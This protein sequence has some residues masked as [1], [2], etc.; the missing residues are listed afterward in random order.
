MAPSARKAKDATSNGKKGGKRA[1]HEEEDEDE[2]A[3]LEAGS[4]GQWADSFIVLCAV[5]WV[6]KSL[7]ALARGSADKANGRAAGV[8]GAPEGSG[9]KKK[10]GAAAAA[11]AT[12]AGVVMDREAFKQAAYEKAKD[13]GI[14]LFLITV[15]VLTCALILGG[16]SFLSDR[17]DRPRE[18]VDDFYGVLGIA[19]DAETA[20]VKRAYKTLARRWHPDKNPNCSVCQ[21]TFSKIAVAY[22]TLG[23]EKKRTSYDESG[24][25]ATTELKSPR[26]VPLT[27][28]NFDQLVT[29]SNDVW[30]V[31]IFKPDDGN[32][33]QFHPFWENQIQK[34][35]H[36]V[37]FGRI[38]VT[39]GMG[40]W[41]PVKVR[42]LPTVLKYGRHLGSPEIFPITA[43]HETPQ[44]LMRFVLTSFPNIG[45][46]L[47]T[48]R[49]GLIR[50]IRSSGRR[51]KV[52]LAIPGKS[53]EERYKSHLMPRKLAARWSELFEFRTAETSMLH[54]LSGENLPD[55]VR[56][57]LPPKGESGSKAAVIFFPA[58]GVAVPRASS[59]VDWPTTEDELVLK[60]LD[61]AE[62]SVPSLSARS[63]DLL[64]RSLAVRRTY[65]LVLVDPPDS[66]AARSMKE[67]NES[68]AVYAEEVEQLRANGDEVSDEE[69]NFI[70]PMVRLFRRPR[71]LQPSIATC[72]AP[73]FG[74][75]DKALGSVGAFLM[76]LDTG[77]V[78][79]LK[80]L[81]SFRGIYPQI[82]YE[83]SL[84]WEEDIMHP[85]LSLPDC[86]EGMVEHLLRGLR[87]APIWAL[88]VQLLTAVFLFEALAKA[89]VER[90]VKW[91][92]GAGALLLLVLLRSPPFLRWVAAYLP[93]A[94]FAQP[95]LV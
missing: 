45:L 25:V 48:D 87:G 95:L 93:G 28:D 58:G 7:F 74:Q 20:D 24:G 16:E 26:S 35:G 88:M 31:Q 30:I 59:I 72:R 86:N 2:D 32:C 80:G 29:F 10:G 52:L 34:H 15:S 49:G 18:A 56:A 70:V 11:T 55:E 62:L 40:S 50:W 67:L 78:A 14:P 75:M 77:R 1:S 89:V 51:H 91:G 17:Y 68:R 66:V 83:D 47:H 22:E 37:R 36:L 12:P 23:D 57:V 76:D 6:F 8:D 71:G 61:A 33:A 85:Y 41:L 4:G 90:S 27:R 13:C 46:P 79:A 38:D 84:K 64:C 9:G 81:S 65:C 53:E 60:L 43:T 54:K 63:A 92:V 69:D 19:R 82:A 73:K 44:T 3:L 42:V 94:L 21:D 39:A 5:R